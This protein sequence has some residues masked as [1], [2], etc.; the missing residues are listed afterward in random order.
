MLFTPGT[1][2]MCE[3]SGTSVELLYCILLL[4]HN[5]KQNFC[6]DLRILANS[7]TRLCSPQQHSPNLLSLPRSST[8]ISVLIPITHVTALTLHG[9]KMR[10]NSNSGPNIDNRSFPRV[11]SER[12]DGNFQTGQYRL[13]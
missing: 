10:P 12:H 4:Q 7:F 11:R 2:G 5:H 1:G 13:L 9:L 8:D 6:N 3:H